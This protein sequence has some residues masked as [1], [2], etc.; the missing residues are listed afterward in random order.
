M[1][2][3][4]RLIRRWSRPD[5]RGQSLVEFALTLPLLLLIVMGTVDL[6]RAYFRVENL[7]NAVKEGAFFGARAPTCD[8][9][10]TPGC[11]DPR[12]V[13]FRVSA[14]ARQRGLQWLHR[15]VLRSGN[16]RL[17][18]SREGAG[19][20]RGRRSLLREGDR[21]LRSH[22]ADPGRPHRQHPQP[23]LRGDIRGPDRLRHH[24]RHHHPD[25]RA[26]ANLAACVV[27]RSRLYEWHEDQP[28]AVGMARYRWVPHDRDDRRPERAA[29][30]VAESPGGLR[31]PLRDHDHYRQ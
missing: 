8:T 5:H 25:A 11:P 1:N 29:D 26:N 30:H 21:P 9:N 19:G 24:W 12:N 22:H 14:G 28:G 18:D 10:L 23:H 31:G 15:S 16:D 4:R 13:Q 6:G 17:H 2:P 3:F 27:H 20:L 7:T